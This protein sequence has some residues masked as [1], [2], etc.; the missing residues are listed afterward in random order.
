VKYARCVKIWSFDVLVL[1]LKCM[2]FLKS[3]VQFL[4]DTILNLAVVQFLMKKKG[5]ARY[6]GASPI[7]MQD[8]LQRVH[9]PLQ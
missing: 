9:L 6:R 1:F 3:C 2:Q 4:M 7:S 5:D 8:A